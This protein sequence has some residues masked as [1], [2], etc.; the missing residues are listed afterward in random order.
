[1]RGVTHVFQAREAVM[2]RIID[3]T[4]GLAFAILFILMVVAKGPAC[5][6]LF[7]L[8]LICGTTLTLRMLKERGLS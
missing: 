8:T 7:A 3:I 6:A 2:A 4:L 1:M 5:T